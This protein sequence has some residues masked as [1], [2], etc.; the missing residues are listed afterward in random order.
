M[1][2][3]P[4]SLPEEMLEDD[5]CKYCSGSGCVHCRGKKADASVQAQIK[6]NL[7]KLRDLDKEA[8]LGS[9]LVEDNIADRPDWQ[10]LKKQLSQKPDTKKH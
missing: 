4:G 10:E 2:E 5:D 8:E 7:K 1:R 9:K 6:A 3:T